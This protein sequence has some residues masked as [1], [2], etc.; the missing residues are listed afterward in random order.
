[1]ILLVGIK[2]VADPNHPAR[3]GPDG[4]AVECGDA[5]EVP[6]PFDLIALEAALRWREAG[7]ATE[8]IVVSAG[9]PSWSEGLSTCLAM[10]SDRAILVELAEAPDAGTAAAILAETARQVG[11][12]WLFTGRQGVDRDLG[13][14]GMM[15]AGLLGWAQASQVVELGP[16]DGEGGVTLLREVDGGLE[17]RYLHP[18]GVISADLRLGEP[19][20]V[21][22]PAILAA[23]RKRVERLEAA[24]LSLPFLP[25]CPVVARREPSPRPGGHLLR[26]VAELMAR[27]RPEFTTP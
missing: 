26:D 14:T 22:L 27:L 4:F 8:V 23:R 1:M 11:A 2:Q 25:G 19:R 13:V 9:P 7:V 12:A 20:C 6:N 17:S 24:A 5:A 21:T 10:G 15:A 3:L 18:P 16:P